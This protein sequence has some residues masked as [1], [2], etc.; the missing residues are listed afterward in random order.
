MP[1]HDAAILRA[2]DGG[3]LLE[4]AAAFVEDGSP[5]H[6]RYAVRLDR[7]WHTRSATVDGWLGTTPVQLGITVSASGDWLL[8]GQS[9][10]AASGALDIDLAFTPATN[11]LPIRRLQLAVGQSSQVVAAWLPFPELTIRPLDQVYRRATADT[12][13]YSSFGGTFQVTLSVSPEGFVTD[14]PGLWAQERGWSIEG[15]PPDPSLQRKPPG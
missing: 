11:L 3:W 5:A 15:G 13:D 7:R 9:V 4:G 12:Y 8:N 10:P 14:Y 6:L 1:G 2:A